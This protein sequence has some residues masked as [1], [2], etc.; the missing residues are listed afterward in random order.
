MSGSVLGTRLDLPEPLVGNYFVATYPPFSCWDEAG[1]EDWLEALDDPGDPGTPLG[2]YVHVPFCVRRCAYCY[3]LSTD[4]RPERLDAY[5]DAVAAEAARVGVAPA[6]AGRGAAFVYFGGGTPSILSPQRLERLLSEIRAAVPWDGA[7]EVTFECA[8]RTVTREK[9]RVLRAHGVTR[10]SMGVQQMDDEVLRRNGRVHR[11]RDVLRAWESIRDAGFPVV[12]LDL[13]AGLVGE[14]ETSFHDGLER[15]L[16][17]GPESVT[18]Y[19]LE[20]PRN[21]PLYRALRDGEIEDVPAGWDV[22]RHRIAGA[23][24]RLEQAGYAVRSAYTAVRDPA[25]HRFVYQDEQYRGADLLGLGVSSFSYLNGVHHQNVATL[26]GY[27]AADRERRLPLWRGRALTPGE[28]AVREMILQL[29]LGRVDRLA[30]LGRHGVDPVERFAQ[31]LGDLVDA[32]FA[33][34]EPASITLTRAGLLRADRLLP[35][36]YLPDHRDIRYS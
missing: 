22:K 23:F 17:L 19:P 6:V 12:N 29:K 34:V 24:A 16:E 21:T 33:H 20:I 32:G 8:P 13:I 1:T 35:S 3:Y 11:V 31:P 36:F 5:L 10:I 2:L 30:F 28:R 25:R 9:L 18:L 14:T 4:T 26:D 7:R 15:I 27:L